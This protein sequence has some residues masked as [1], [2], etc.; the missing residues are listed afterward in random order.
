MLTDIQ[1]F[2]GLG[3]RTL[4]LPVGRGVSGSPYVITSIDGLGPVKAEILST[5][6]AD[7]D[8]ALLQSRR[9]G[10]RNIVLNIRYRPD[11]KKNK[12]VEDLRR[13]LYTH[14]PPKNEIALRFLN[15]KYP[16]T[17]IKPIV[18]TNDPAIF[19]KEPEVQISLVA[20]EPDFYA[21]DQVVH[22]GSNLIAASKPKYAGSARTGF[23]LDI[24]VKSSAFS[25]TIANGIQED[26]VYQGNVVAGDKLLISTQKANKYVK[27]V[28]GGVYSNV[29][30]GLVKGDL[31]MV[32]EPRLKTFSVTTGNGASFSYTMTYSEKYMGL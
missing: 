9:T 3:V 13:E 30:E 22:T 17:Q 10:T 24:D 29:L 21:L 19:A 16:I 32:I 20:G 11:Y 25:F 5:T 2:D 18:E 23:L 26:I 15:S 8:G 27:L 31:S 4:T 6:Y 1:V 12:T 28:R 14:F 7:Y